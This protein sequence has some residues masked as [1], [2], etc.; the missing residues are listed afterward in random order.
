MASRL[1]FRPPS[2]HLRQRPV[3]AILN[4][5]QCRPAMRFCHRRAQAVIDSLRRP[6]NRYRQSAIVPG[7]MS[8]PMGSITKPHHGVGT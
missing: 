8:V 6:Q 3:F 2:H 7:G 4:N 1:K 5:V